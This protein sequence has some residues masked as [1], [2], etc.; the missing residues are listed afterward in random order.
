[1]DLIIAKKFIKHKNK[2][3]NKIKR[4]GFLR[5]EKIARYC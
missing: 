1:M 2:E 3:T 4:N 5:N